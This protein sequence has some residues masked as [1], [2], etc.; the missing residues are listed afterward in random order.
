MKPK[1]RSLIA[2]FSPFKRASIVIC[3]T[4]SAA[5]LQAQ[6]SW[7]GASDG[8]WT[9]AGNWN[10]TI[11][12]AD[13]VAAFDAGSLANLTIDLDGDQSVGGLSVTSP[14]GAVIFNNDTLTTGVDGI[15]M[16]LATQN[17]T[18]NSSVAL[19]G[20]ES[21]TWA[22]GSG[23]TLT[24]SNLLVEANGATLDFDLSGGGTV[25]LSGATPSALVNSS[26]TIKTATDGDFAALDGSNNVVEANT[27]LTYTP[28]PNTDTTIPNFAGTYDFV[29]V[30]NSNLDT[31]GNSAYR[32]SNNLTVNYGV[33][34]NTP[35]F[36]VTTATKADWQVDI[37]SRAHYYFDGFH[38]LVTENVDTDVLFNGGA[39]GF[40]ASTSGL[41]R[42]FVTN[43]SANDIFFNV[44]FSQ[45]G[46]RD[47][48]ITKSGT[49]D[50]FFTH[51][52]TYATTGYAFTEG[53]TYLGNNG[54][55]GA[56]NGGGIYVSDGATFA[57]NRSDDAGTL[58]LVIDGPGA[59]TQVGDGV[60]G[61]SGVNTFTGGTTISNGGIGASAVD[62]FGSGPV[63]IDGGKVRFD[64]AFDLTS[65]VVSIGSSG[66]EL[67][68]NGNDATLAGSFETGSTGSLTKTG[69]GS[70]SLDGDNDYSGGTTVTAGTLLANATTSSTGSGAVT[71]N[72]G[73]TL[74]GD[75]VIAGAV[76]IESGA[77]V[78]PGNSV[79]EVTTASLDLDAGSLATFE[80]NITPAN[81]HIVVT[82]GG[83]LTIDG[84]AF[85]LVQE[86]TSTPFTTPGT[87][88]LIGYSGAIGGA[89]VGSL[90]VSNAQ[91]GFSYTFAATGSE[92]TV[93]I[94]T[95][96]VVAQW[97]TDGG[98]LWTTGS[99]WSTDPTIPNGQDET[100]LFTTE[101]T[102]AS[103]VDL[104]GAKTLGA[105]AFDS[106]NAYTLTQ[107]AA[108]ALTLDN[109]GGTA[110]IGIL[111]GVH[112]IAADV[113]LTSD[114]AT[115]ALDAAD[116]LDISGAVSGAGG[117]T[118]TGAGSLGLLAS[119][120]F[121]G[122]VDLQGGTT[123][124]ASGG[125][126]AGTTVSLDDSTLVWDAGNTDDISSKTVAFGTNPVT[127]DVGANNVSLA[128][129]IGDSGSSDLTKAGSGTLTVAADSAYSGNTAIT[130]GTL[131]VG[132]GAAAGSVNGDI[133]N[134]GAL[135]IN[136]SDNV[137]IGNIISGTGSLEQAGSGDLA[138]SA[139]NTFSGQTDISAGTLTLMDSLALQNST[140][141]YVSGGGTLSFDTLT[142]ATFGALQGDLDLTLENITPAGVALTVGGNGATTTYSGVLSGTGASLLK[143]GAGVFTL[144]GANT[145]DGSTFVN[146][147]TLE[148][149]GSISGTTIATGAGDILNVNGGSVTSSTFCDIEGQLNIDLGGVANYNGGVRGDNSDGSII[150]VIDGT[151]NALSVERRR[152]TSYGDAALPSVAPGATPNTF[153]LVVGSNG[154]ANI[155]DLIVGTS[156][157][158]GSAVVDGG[159]LNVTG[160]V[161]IGNTSNT[162]WS[163]MDAISGECNLTDTVNGVVL[164][165]NAGTANKAAFFASGATTKVG[166][167]TFGDAAGAAGTGLVWVTGELYMGAGGAV[168]AAPVFTSTF[169]LDGG[170][171][172]AYANTSLSVPVEIASISTIYAGDELA[173]PF[174]IELAGGITGSD[175]IDLPGDGQ[176]TIT[177]A[178]GY[179]GNINVLE[180][181]LRLTDKTLD[182]SITVNVDHTFGFTTPTLLLEYSGGDR[183][184]EF[185]I[186]G[187]AQGPGIY[188]AVGSGAP[189]ETSA[190]DAASTGWL[191]VDTAVPVSGYTS[192]AGGAGL[193]GGVNDAG[194]DNPESDTNDNTLEYIMNGDPLASD[195]LVDVTE[196]ATHVIYTFER[197]DDSET[198]T[199]LNFLWSTSLT[200]SWTT[201]AI[202]AT[203]STSPDNVEVIITEDGGPSGA[204]YD[205]I[206]VKLPKVL[207]TGGE[208]FGRFQGVLNP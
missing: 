147:G 34:F 33:R 76:T 14:A 48:L 192:W 117:V 55:S 119:N 203:S 170:T 165:P 149:T 54:T 27:V 110:D 174:D 124:F 139:A 38:I 66:A 75:G 197:F 67:D 60:M 191:Y 26:S 40:R 61:L 114:L 50:V 17:L 93:T 161:T 5:S 122:D 37:G 70:L 62:A 181:Q 150:N 169:Q 68:T 193:T 22:V 103:S 205:L 44:G 185:E 49:G 42:M 43:N 113:A 179:T 172:G 200:G 21:Q 207:A 183:V 204:A 156:N 136:R 163:V 13:E 208:V 36:N 182:D 166:K 106:A 178:S 130:A 127:L 153:G 65:A 173:N 96:G 118:K 115:E 140:L 59:L 189:T 206:V 159:E 105:M 7:T 131:Q 144:S 107:G 85:E 142:A 175:D 158:S 30:I 157:S 8:L 19:A 94:A 74:G 11:P 137:T 126:G 132:T 99:N 125:L 77:T 98:G 143:N 141:N 15:D 1:Y 80:F 152:D 188:G 4:L 162:R 164:A 2:A 134:D 28:N 9:T 72:S 121:T 97:V 31:W 90:S 201:V 86:G 56:L 88:N 32:L 109:S 102:T 57:L 202:G 194:T 71:V 92:V 123:T 146:E 135:V 100:A 64:G 39:T 168:Q 151:L 196:D 120:S 138:L 53:T 82:S 128:N 52:D 167:F 190:I 46:G 41:C 79:G 78:A 20:N 195:V 47:A 129:P 51:N 87:Y 83:G 63:L 111:N 133:A 91:P 10:T 69:A 84:G 198:D 29:D 3:A 180:G 45:V 108:G 16:S 112:E 12:A 104:D 186:D 23:A 6:Q 35:H 89:G 101:L 176:V 73:A 25:N 177:N 145:Y 155:G 95:T 81:D 199:D 160:T 24:L 58:G 154:I 116:G 148:V 18:L 187:V 171:L 184:M